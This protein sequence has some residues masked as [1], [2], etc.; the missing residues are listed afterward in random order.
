MIYQLQTKKKNQS[1]F[2]LLKKGKQQGVVEMVL[3]TKK[4][5]IYLPSHG[6]QI[7]FALAGTDMPLHIDEKMPPIPPKGDIF[8]QYPL[9]NQN[10]SPIVINEAFHY[11]RDN[12]LQRDVEIEVIEM[13]KVGNTFLGRLFVK[14]NNSSDDFANDLL[15][16]GYLR[17]NSYVSKKIFTETQCSQLST[18]ETSAKNEKRGFWSIYNAKRENDIIERNNNAREKER[19]EIQANT[20]SDRCIV[21][22]EILSG[23]YFFYQVATEK[24]KKEIEDLMKEFGA[25]N[26]SEKPVY[27]PVMP[28]QSNNSLPQPLPRV[29]GNFSVDNTWYRAEVLEIIN[30]NDQPTLYK[31]RYIDYGN[32]E[33]VTVD[34]IRAL[35]QEFQK[36]PAQAKKAKLA[37]IT[38]P[39][40]DS[41]FGS[42][43]AEFFKSLCWGKDLLANVQFSTLVKEKG[44]KIES[45][46][47]HI[48]LGDEET[49]IFINAAMVMHGFANVDSKKKLPQ[50]GVKW[51]MWNILKE[52]E[53]NAKKARLNIWQYGEYGSDDDEKQFKKGKK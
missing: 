18:I 50:R 43:A 34:R 3:S 36:T 13:S 32:T 14:H 38:A 42:E 41:E 22:T 52:E 20:S 29:A 45:E 26:F 10:G 37:Y 17:L 44:S 12:L 5:K 9:R 15:R 53:E 25:V 27:T 51:P 19:T 4:F 30:N 31:L 47:H 35:P 23:S 48:T 40:T 7:A 28:V 2:D 33:T 6:A 8:S 16:R 24:S 49:K 1:F 46:L 39:D 21:V 11:S